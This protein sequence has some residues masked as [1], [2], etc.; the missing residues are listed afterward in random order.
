[1][2]A[3]ASALFVASVLFAGPAAAFDTDQ[4]K[5]RDTIANQGIK[6]ATTATKTF[7]G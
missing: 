6:L 3:F 5:C 7:A 1:M 2:S 4:Q